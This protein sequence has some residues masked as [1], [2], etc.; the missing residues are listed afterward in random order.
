MGRRRY[1]GNDVLG[2]LDQLPEHEIGGF[3]ADDQNNQMETQR[4]L[5]EKKNTEHW[6]RSRP[7]QKIGNENRLHLVSLSIIVSSVEHNQEFS[8][9]GRQSDVWEHFGFFNG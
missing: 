5:S 3:T 8:D 7:A 2:I 4:H 9:K 1:F 6:L